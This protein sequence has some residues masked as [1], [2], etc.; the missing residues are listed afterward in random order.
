VSL[1]ATSF[2]RSSD[3]FQFAASVAAFGLL[4]RDSQ[5]VGGASF[6]AVNEW[7][8]PVVGDAGDQYRREFLSL[9][10]AAS[11]LKPDLRT[12]RR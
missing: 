10:R 12:A 5:H 2:E 4:L 8:A 9:V 11:E 7:A 3:D 6:A 1:T